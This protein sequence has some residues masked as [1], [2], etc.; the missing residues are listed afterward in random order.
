MFPQVLRGR[1]DSLAPVPEVTVNEYS[2][3]TA[4]EHVIR[5]ATSR[6]VRTASCDL[7]RIRRFFSAALSK[8]SQ[9]VSRLLTR[10]ILADTSPLIDNRG[11][12]G[13]KMNDGLFAGKTRVGTQAVGR[14]MSP[15]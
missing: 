14:S 6:G 5:V 15:T 3:A 2:D 13:L 10:F 4:A 9:A 7:I 8:S 11:Y 12:S 1:F